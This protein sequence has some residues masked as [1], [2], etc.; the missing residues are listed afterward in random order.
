MLNLVKFF[1]NCSNNKRC[2]KS[3][4][5]LKLITYFGSSRNIGLRNVQPR[6]SGTMKEVNLKI[7]QRLGL[8]TGYIKE[9]EKR[10]HLLKYTP[11]QE[12]LPK[13]SMKD[14][15]MEAYIPLSICTDMQVNYVS[16]VGTV[17]LGRLMEQLDMFAVWICQQH[18]SI[19]KLPVNEP[20]P[21]TF[22]TILV[23]K[24]TFSKLLPAYNQDIRITG[25]VSWVG[26]TSL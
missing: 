13:R 20:L 8:E 23:D 11:L 5:F 21:Y 2:P 15:Y 16:A 3:S 26:R 10:D 12:E 19:P 7:M 22:V 24:M 18:V 4:V 9:A 25:H 6:K 17:R 14:S 1:G